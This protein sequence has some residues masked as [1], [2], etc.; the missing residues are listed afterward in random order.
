MGWGDIKLLMIMSLI[1]Q[2][3]VLV[4]LIGGEMLA[5]I[6]SLVLIMKDPWSRK[7]KIPLAP[8]F[9]L[10]IKL[11]SEISQITIILILNVI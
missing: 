10:I 7:K 3:G 1:F 4:I 8:F 11:L 5:S 6:Y 2:E 9:A